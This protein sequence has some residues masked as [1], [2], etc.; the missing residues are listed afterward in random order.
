MSGH[1]PSLFFGKLSPWLAFTCPLLTPRRGNGCSARSRI[2]DRVPSWTESQAPRRVP[3]APSPGQAPPPPAAPA[4]FSAPAG[5]A[6]AMGPS[7]P[8][9][10]ERYLLRGSVSAQRPPAVPPAGCAVPGAGE[11]DG[12]P[13]FGPC[14]S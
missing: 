2:A 11:A 5:R 14:L 3:R 4:R 7:R 8:C 12:L 1:L 10:P 13:Y 6:S 9:C